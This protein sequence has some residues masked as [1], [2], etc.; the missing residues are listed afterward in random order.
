MI[1]IANLG[2]RQL[3]LAFEAAHSGQPHIEHEAACRVGV[4]AFEEA[5]SRAEKLDLQP[6]RLEKLL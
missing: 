1:G 2:V 5:F 3:F 4:F 6:D